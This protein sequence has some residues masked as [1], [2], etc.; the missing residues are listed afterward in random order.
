MMDHRATDTDD[1]DEQFAISHEIS[2]RKGGSLEKII[3]EKPRVNSLH[4]QSINILAPGLQAEATAEDGTIEAVTV[5]NSKG[6]ATG[7]QWHP[8]YWSETDDTSRSLFE[9][10]GDEV[11]AYAKTKL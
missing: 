1:R 6:F 2:V 4:A 8:E 3:G 10:F 11:R 5:I 7:V 9:A